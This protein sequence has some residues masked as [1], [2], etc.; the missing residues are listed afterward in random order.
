MSKCKKR[1]EPFTPERGVTRATAIIPQ[2][3]H[4]DVLFGCCAYCHSNVHDLNTVS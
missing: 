1:L 2:T 3:T 4:F